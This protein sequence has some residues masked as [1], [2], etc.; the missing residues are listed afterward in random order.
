MPIWTDLSQRGIYP[1]EVRMR[2]Y[3]SFIWQPRR[4]F[5]VLATFGAFAVVAQAPQG[6]EGQKPPSLDQMAEKLPIG[7]IPSE[8]LGIENSDALFTAQGLKYAIDL[9]RQGGALISVA[10]RDASDDVQI[11]FIGA[12]ANPGPQ[13]AEELPGKVFAY[14]GNRQEK[15]DTNVRSF[16]RIVFRGLYRGVDIAYYGTQQL[17]EFDMI[18]HP[19][20]DPSEIKFALASA[21]G[22]SWNDAGGLVAGTSLGF[23]TLPKPVAYQEIGGTRKAVE[24]KYTLDSAASEVGFEVESYD[25]SQPLII[26]PVL[27]WTIYPNAPALS[28]AD[29]AGKAVAVD[30]YG[31]VWM[32]GWRVGPGA[33]NL[34]LVRANSSGQIAAQ[35]N[36]VAQANCAVGVSP[37]GQ[38]AQGLA[39]DGSDGV[40]IAGWSSCTDF[41]V[42]NAAQSSR[43]GHVDGVL[44]HFSGSTGIVSST[45]LGGTSEDT[46]YGVAVSAASGDVWVAGRTSSSNFPV[47]GTSS[48]YAGG[49]YDGFIARY[50][51]SGALLFSRYLGGHRAMLP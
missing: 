3:L 34:Y 33:H 19:G 38:E 21:K 15:W 24:I 49:A 7:F 14:V 16:A 17:L 48:A 47:V 32:A 20:G 28:A 36:I 12:N 50:S 27:N 10:S 37:Y 9:N 2:S 45:Y 30:S 41:P 13:T 22:I 25:R 39:S 18:V 40:W 51:S 31:L 11:S 46:A 44:M 8:K 5:V 43:A 35:G 23:V 29:S 1:I 42:L 4:L 26:D 6:G